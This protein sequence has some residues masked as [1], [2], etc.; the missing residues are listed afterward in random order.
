MTD[1]SAIRRP[2]SSMNGSF[3]F[4]PLRGSGVSMISY[5]MRA[6]RSHVSSLQQNGLRFGIA[7][8]RGNWNSLMVWCMALVIGSIL[9]W[10]ERQSSRVEAGERSARYAHRIK[11]ERDAACQGCASHRWWRYDHR[12]ARTPWYR[13]IRLLPATLNQPGH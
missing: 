10:R 6:I 9:V 2:A 5:G 11:T 3:P 1:V 4:G 7:N 12:S 8:M 13:S